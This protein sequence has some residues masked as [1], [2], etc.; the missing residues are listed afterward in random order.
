MTDWL[1]LDSA[2]RLLAD[3]CTYESVQEAERTGWSAPVWDALA[4]SGYTDTTGIELQDAVGLLSLAGEFAVPVPLAETVLAGWLL[5]APPEGAITVAPQGGL[6]FEGSTVSGTAPGVPWGRAVER[7]VVLIDRR[8]VVLPTERASVEERTN[9]AG[10]PR[11][12]LTFDRAHPDEVRAAAQDV[13]ELGALT[14]AAMMS[15]A[16]TAAARLTIGYAAQRRQ[17]GRPIASFQAVQ[18]HLVSIAQEVSLVVAAVQGAAGAAKRGRAGFEIAAAKVLASQAAGSATR[19]AHQVHGAMGMTQEYRL[20]HFTR[21]LWAWRA[22]Y[23]DEQYWSRRL[24]GSMA[25]AGADVLYPAITGGSR[26]I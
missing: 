18:Q 4:G 19:A 26:V 2:R 5:A 7:V 10:E 21:R 12:R 22:E 13:R 24:G 11:D 3:T 6:R 8:L 9:L 15:G 20:H 25:A 23:G 14:R 16:L 1:L 17:F